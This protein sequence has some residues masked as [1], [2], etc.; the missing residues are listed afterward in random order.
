MLMAAQVVAA[1][2]PRIPLP[3]SIAAYEVLLNKIESG[4]KDAPSI[5]TLYF[6]GSR[7]LR[8]ILTRW[9]EDSQGHR[10]KTLNGQSDLFVADALTV[11]QLKEISGRLKGFEIIRG[12]AV[13]H[14]RTDPDFF[15]NLAKRRG[16]IADQKYFEL[17]KVT[18]DQDEYPVFES[19]VSD[20]GTCV[21]YGSDGVVNFYRQWNDFKQKYP[22]AYQEGVSWRMKEVYSALT[23]RLCAC[24]NTEEPVKNEFRHFL[25]EFP[26]AEIS[27]EVATV[28]HDIEAGRST[29]R[30]GCTP[31]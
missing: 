5:E 4:S 3:K 20:Y 26:K 27:A 10:L 16:G 30:L 15:L 13:I 28:L 6:D 31:G 12:A 14:I 24:G 17:L 21:D 9:A 23:Q 1:E 25:S 22:Q 8:E 2:T 7:V 18:T 29:L 19:W 11:D